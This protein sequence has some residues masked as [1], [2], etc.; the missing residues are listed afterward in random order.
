[1]KVR[2]DDNWLFVTPIEGLVL[3]SATKNEIK[4]NRVTFISKNKLPYVRLRFG[5]PVKFSQLSELVKTNAGTFVDKFLKESDTYALLPYKGNP[6]DKKLENKNIVQDE[7]N[8]LLLSLLHCEKRKFNSKVQIKE[9]D[10]HNYHRGLNIMKTTPQFSLGWDALSYMIVKLD[11]DWH[12]FQKRYFYYKFLKLINEQNSPWLNILTQA[13]KILGKGQNESDLP[14]ALLFNVIALEMLLTNQNDKISE[15]LI[16]RI[17]FFLDW[18]EEWDEQNFTE[19]I[20]DLYSKRC[21]YVHDGNTRG[22]TKDDVIFSDSIAFNIL[23]N[24]VKFIHQ[25]P[26]KTKLI[27]LSDKYACEKKLGLE[28]KKYQKGK[29]EFQRIRTE[30]MTFDDL[31][32]T[33]HNKP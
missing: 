2:K 20:K 18:C 7:L 26:S 3:T 11:S 24:I 10:A 22:I 29:F 33:L 32:K 19:K 15:K 17:A 25:I 31:V 21:L 6:K 30:K 9:N 5:L 16:E 13:G 28:S 1:M 4:I 27:E 12:K 8:I 23:N 14:N